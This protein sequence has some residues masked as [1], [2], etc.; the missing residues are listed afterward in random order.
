[1]VLCRTLLSVI[2]LLSIAC[3]GVVT[4]VSASTGEVA[5]K[6]GDRGIKGAEGPAGPTGPCPP[7]EGKQV[8]CPSKSAETSCSS[9]PSDSTDART[10][11][12]TEAEEPHP[13]VPDATALV[14][15]LL[16]PGPVDPKG[17]HGSQGSG[18]ASCS[19]GGESDVNCPSDS[20]ETSC[21]S[22]PSD[23]NDGR[24]CTQVAGNGHNSDQP[25]GTAGERGDQGPAG[26]VGTR[27]GSDTQT[28]SDPG[29]SSAHPNASLPSESTTEERRDPSPTDSQT[30]QRGGITTEE[31]VAN[32][33]G[34]AAQPSSSSSSSTTESAGAAD[35]ETK[36]NG[37]SSAES[38]STG[39]QST[40]TTT[41]TTTTTTTLH[42]D[43]ANNKKGDADSSSSI[44]S[45]VWV[46]LPLLIVVTLAC[47]LVC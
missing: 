17:S 13:R 27:Q 36:E 32:Q 5:G 11:T 46:R 45:S 34:D 6:E 7:G 1:M 2:L 4:K 24:T 35:N 23:S 15:P 31:S 28:G 26:T 40:S 33:G 20:A 29:S 47:I 37:T 42:P 19:E 22:T 39:E 10:C 43:P 3:V 30:E 18:K 9:T 8:T 21:S 41:T 14:P 12:Q 44:S 25:P 16:P 38:E